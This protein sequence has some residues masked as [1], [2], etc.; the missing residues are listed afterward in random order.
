MHDE[1]IRTTIKKI[2]QERKDNQ[3]VYRFQFFE[4][5]IC[6]C[7]CFSL[8]QPITS[9]VILQSMRSQGFESFGEVQCNSL[10]PF[11]KRYSLEHIKASYTPHGAQVVHLKY[12]TFLVYLQLEVSHSTLFHA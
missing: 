7:L 11:D 12:F 3:E 4:P 6:Y 9:Y 5:L 1:K 10:K 8:H 2:E